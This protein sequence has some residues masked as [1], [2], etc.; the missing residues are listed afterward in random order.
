MTL[1]SPIDPDRYVGTVTLV[2]ASQIQANLPLATA[3]PE[4]RGLSKG[5]VG[6]FVFVDCER[7]KLLGRIVEVKI[8]DAERLSVEPQLGTPASPHPIGRIQLLATAAQG[9]NRL[10]RGLKFYPRIGDGVYLAEPMLLAEL[11][12]NAVSDHDELTLAVGTIDA[13]DGLAIRLPPEKLFGRH[14]GVFGATGGGKSWTIATLIHELKKAHGKALIF[15]P[16]GE[17]AGLKA[18]SSVFL[19]KVAKARRMSIFPIAK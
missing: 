4:K 17:F 10:T 2:N 9:S 7:V 13:A 12:R 19:N 3:R 6:D 16:T 14:C 18:V 5:A 15:D 1:Q 8:P 11:I